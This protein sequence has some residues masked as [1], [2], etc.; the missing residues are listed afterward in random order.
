[1]MIVIQKREERER[2]FYGY[3]HETAHLFFQYNHEPISYDFG[4]GYGK[5][6]LY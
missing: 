2:L 5:E 1:M 6:K 4:R 3:M